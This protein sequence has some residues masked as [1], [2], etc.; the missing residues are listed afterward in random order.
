MSA[1]TEHVARWRD[2]DLCPLACQRSRIV[3]ARGSVPC[4]VL[5][6]GEAPGVSED[7]LGL[8]FVGPAGKLLDRIVAASVPDGVRT[9]FTN[10]VACFPRKAKERGDNEPEPEEIEACQDRLKEFVRIA[11][12]RA[13]VLVGQLARRYV[14]GQAQF[15]E[16]REDSQPPWLN[17]EFMRFCDVDHPAFILKSPEVAQGMLIKRAVVRIKNLVKEL[18]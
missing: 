1:W 14:I 15:C 16:D 6:V 9:A 13:I 5:L 11:R 4:D 8:P 10:L 7:A 18:Q 2:C 3:L 17:G 12:P